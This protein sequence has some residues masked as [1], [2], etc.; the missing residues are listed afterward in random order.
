MASKAVSTSV[1]TQGEKVRAVKIQLVNLQ[2]PGIGRQRQSYRPPARIDMF[3]TFMFK[4]YYF[5]YKASVYARD[6]RIGGVYMCW[7]LSFIVG[8]VADML[9]PVPNRPLTYYVTGTG[10]KS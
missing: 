7:V 10:Q 8:R 5:V 1:R 2:A 4:D 9:A 3:V 6:N